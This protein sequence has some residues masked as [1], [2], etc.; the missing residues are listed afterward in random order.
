MD[1]DDSR[2]RPADS[3]Y[4]SSVKRLCQRSPTSSNNGSPGS[5]N[6]SPSMNRPCI[7]SLQ[8]VKDLLTVPLEFIFR[9]CPSS[10][11]PTSHTQNSAS[12]A[13]ATPM[14]MSQHRPKPLLSRNEASCLIRIQTLAAEL[15][16]LVQF[17]AKVL[18][19]QVEWM[20]FHDELARADIRPL[21]ALLPIL[22]T[23]GQ[24]FAHQR[25]RS[26]HGDLAEVLK[27]L[28]TLGENLRQSREANWT[29]SEALLEVLA[30]NAMALE[31]RHLG[32]IQDELAQRIDSLVKATIL[33]E[34][35]RPDEEG[36][37][38]DILSTE[39]PK[40]MADF[41]REVW[42]ESNFD[43]G[44]GGD[45]SSSVLSPLRQ[46][47]SS[48]Q[49]LRLSVEPTG[50]ENAPSQQHSQRSAVVEESPAVCLGGV[51]ASQHA[52][53]LALSSLA[54]STTPN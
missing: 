10:S 14:M 22:L 37:E 2:K 15:D 16:S 31:K 24:T 8:S 18:M 38:Q 41:C 44:S 17:S 23:L 33:D 40:S 3:E 4:C 54:F 53:A 34:T 28:E 48:S 12:V 9:Q 47:S 51:S 26:L 13:A 46:S 20:S 42:K 27:E 50:K 35:W 43:S 7:P 5:G 25:L 45:S 19:E 21:R 11:G 32:D 39:A 29:T 6:D 30:T 49:N 36:D 52:G 1:T